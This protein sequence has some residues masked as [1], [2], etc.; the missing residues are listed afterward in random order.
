M[1]YNTKTQLSNSKSMSTKSPQPSKKKKILKL[2]IILLIIIFLL[3]VLSK[4]NKNKESS[5]LNDGQT[6]IQTQGAED[7]LN[8]MSAAANA[9]MKAENNTIKMEDSQKKILE[10]FNKAN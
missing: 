2:L 10:K 9:V 4:L 6:S 5:T 7:V 3:N 8:A 1:E